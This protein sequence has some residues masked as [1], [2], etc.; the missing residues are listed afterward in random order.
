MTP[1]QARFV[2]EYLIDL[3]ASAAAR[4]AGYRPNRADV[5]GYENLLKPEIQSAI[6]AA[7]RERSARTGITADRVITEIA[8]VAF[9]DPRKVMTWGPGGVVLRDSAELT[10]DEAATVSEVVETRTE[11]G[12]SV[13]IKLHSKLDALEKLAR[14]VG[15]YSQETGQDI[16]IVNPRRFG[17]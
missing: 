3:N 10:D 15:V 7:Q 12:C 9:A 4:R 8:K 5:I 2:E 16:V 14:H 1:K 11:S 13:K 17:S 6:E